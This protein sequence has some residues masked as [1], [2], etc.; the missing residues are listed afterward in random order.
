MRG[1]VFKRGR[2]W[3]AQVFLGRDAVTG[4]K[5]YR[6]WGGFPTRRAAEQ[7]LNRQLELLRV[8]EYADAGTTTL[9]DF[10]DRWLESVGTR[11]RPTTAASYRDML[12]G[13]VVPRIGNVRLD[14]LKPMTLS[15]LYTDLLASGRRSGSG[16]LAPRTVQYVHR[17]VSRALSDAVRWNLLARKPASRVDAPRVEM[18][19]MRTWTAADVRRFLGVARTLTDC[20][21]ELPMRVLDARAR[22]GQS[23]RVR[24]TRART[25]R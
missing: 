15:S 11:V 17:I 19:E 22:I 3:T 14:Q 12:E 18:K 9:A 8:G 5:R 6:Q 1:S 21:P 24:P 4:R 25:P 13:H 23:V 16:G 10:L 7:A 2:S 20:R